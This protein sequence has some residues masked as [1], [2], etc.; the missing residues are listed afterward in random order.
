MSR[1]KC[2]EM[3]NNTPKAKLKEAHKQKMDRKDSERKLHAD[4]R[5]NFSYTPIIGNLSRRHMK[6]G[7]HPS[8]SYS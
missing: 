3:P 6:R 8:K 2:K 4:R 7:L 1:T 5:T